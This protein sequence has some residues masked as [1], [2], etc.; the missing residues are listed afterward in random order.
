MGKKYDP[1]WTYTALGFFAMFEEPP[2]QKPWWKRLI[3]WR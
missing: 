3:W 2:K 1:W